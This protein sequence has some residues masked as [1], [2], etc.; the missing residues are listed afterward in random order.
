MSSGDQPFNTW[1]CPPEVVIRVVDPAGATATTNDRSQDREQGSGRA[2]ARAATEATTDAAE[3]GKPMT[4]SAA[5]ELDEATT[6]AGAAASGKPVTARAATAGSGMARDGLAAWARKTGRLQ[7]GKA[8]LEAHIVDDHNDVLQYI[9]RA[10][11]RKKL[12]TSGIT[13]V[14]F[15][16]HPDAGLPMELRPETVARPAALFDAVSISEFIMPAVY[17]GY[18]SHFVWIKPPWAK[19]FVEMPPAVLYNPATGAVEANPE[20][21]PGTDPATANTSFVAWVGENAEG[22]LRIGCE[23]L[24]FDDVSAPR[25]ELVNAKPVRIDV[26]SL[27]AR[28]C[29]ADHDHLLPVNTVDIEMTSAVVVDVCLDFF[30]VANPFLLDYDR[31][32]GPGTFAVFQA[33]WDYDT[34]RWDTAKRRTC[35]ELFNHGIKRLVRDRIYRKPNDVFWDEVVALGLPDLY[36]DTYGGDIEPVSGLYALF[37]ETLLRMEASSASTLPTSSVASYPPVSAADSN[38][39]DGFATFTPDLD[40]EDV[41]LSGEMHDLPHAL[42]TRAEMEHLLSGMAHFL[43]RPEL[44]S[45]SLITMAR[46]RDD[47]YTPGASSLVEWLQTRSLDVLAA[48]YGDLDVF[49]HYPDPVMRFRAPPPPGSPSPN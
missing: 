34:R 35:F 48:Q 4:G 11:G 14:H 42:V 13:L 10:I 41:L 6:G 1:T 36:A 45:P 29:S 26:V 25:D 44:A 9:Y 32:Y 33:V 8:R 40:W 15:D 7:R 19:Q 24:Y 27:P 3:S 21:D 31:D 39:P 43:A 17:S 28:P 47:G 5:A 38:D 2:A 20:H 16:S 18:L 30:N 22:V 37:R 46:S 12:P 23:N 49:P